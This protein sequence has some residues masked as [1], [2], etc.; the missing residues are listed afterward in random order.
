MTCIFVVFMSLHKYMNINIYVKDTNE[1][2]HHLFTHFKKAYDSFRRDVY[3]NIPITFGIP[4][5]LVS[6]MK[7]CL[8]ETYSNVRADKHLTCFL[9]RMVKKKELLYYHCFSTSL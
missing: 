1:E 6:L 2:V 5:K 7:M 4:M 8:N 9:L 3:H